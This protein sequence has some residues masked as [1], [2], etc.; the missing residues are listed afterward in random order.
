MGQASS[1]TNVEFWDEKI[2]TNMARDRR[3]VAALRRQGWGVAVVWECQLKKRNGDK[4]L[5]RIIRF[6]GI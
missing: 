5:S 4:W 2:R 1:K 6:L 3:N